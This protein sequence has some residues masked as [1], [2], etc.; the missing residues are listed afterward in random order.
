MD[1]GEA[2]GIAMVEVEEPACNPPSTDFTGWEAVIH[3]IKGKEGSAA[4]L[5]SN[6]L[7]AGMSA[8]ADPDQLANGWDLFDCDQQ[9]FPCQTHHL[10]PEKQL[11]KHPVTLWLTDSPKS[12]CQDD[13]YELAKDTNYDTNG[14]KNGY[15]MPFASTTHQWNSTSSGS[16]KDR[17]CFEMMRRTKK[18]LHQ[19]PHSRSSDYAEELDIETS[20]YKSQVDEFLTEIDRNVT[21]H[22]KNCQKG[23][24]DNSS[25]KMK[26]QP[27]LS[28]VKMVEQASFLLKVLT[29]RY[30]IH[31]SRRAGNYTNDYYDSSKSTVVHPNTP[32]ITAAEL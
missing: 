18:Q 5:K 22:V 19:G 16:K 12:S 8:P 15:F 3:D 32:I 26:V 29:Q 28:T 4:D 21:A 30:H 10:I 27:L 2:A 11:P 23:C 9:T 25:P 6:M 31:V 7:A 17:I 24:K 14:A 13:N 1:I 20:A